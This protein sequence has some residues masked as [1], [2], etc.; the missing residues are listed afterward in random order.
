MFQ[1]ATL[2]V[3]DLRHLFFCRDLPLLTTSGQINAL[4]LENAEAF[5]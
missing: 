1:L 2:A 3:I 5:P 4:E